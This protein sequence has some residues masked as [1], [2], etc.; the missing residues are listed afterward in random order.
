[1]SRQRPSSAF[2][3]GQPPRP[4]PAPRARGRAPRAREPPARPGEAAGGFRAPA[5][6]RRAGSR[7]HG[8]RP[9]RP[10]PR[11]CP[12]G[13]AER[14]GGRRAPAGPGAGA[15]A[16]TGTGA[17]TAAMER[18]GR[19][20]AFG[21][22]CPNKVQGPP[23]RL[24]KKQARPGGGPAGTPPPALSPRAPPPRPRRSGAPPAPAAPALG[25]SVRGG[26]PP[27]TGR[28]PVPLPP[29]THPPSVPH[30][31]PL[32][33]THPTV[34]STVSPRPRPPLHAPRC[35]P[36]PPPTL[37][38]P[39]SPRHAPRG[40]PPATVPTSPHP[41]GYARPWPGSSLLSLTVPSAHHHRLAGFGS[42]CP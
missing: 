31:H 33:V 7:G 23:P 26:E 22:I 32:A 41:P 11:P 40:C 36:P 6:G 21:S 19:R 2:P 15:G 30:L 34:P 1:M 37:P 3:P 8:P 27:S 18:G 13:G 24:A 28:V 14:G 38:S 4:A 39:A 16:G 35:A 42:L 25:E 5:E 10:C 20:R 29:T 9:P 17:A 12:R